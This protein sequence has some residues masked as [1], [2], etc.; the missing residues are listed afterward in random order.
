MRANLLQL[1]TRNWPIKGAALFLALMLYV[2]VQLQQPVT[3]SFDVDL[4]V[5]LPPGRALVHRPPKVRVQISGKGSQIL[6]LRSLA[7]DI[8]RRLPDTLTAT[9]WPIHLDPSEVELALPKGADVRVLDIRP[10]DITIALDSVARKDVRIVSLVTVMPESG[11]M[12]H[13]GLSISPTTARLVGPEKSLAGIESV[14]TVQTEITNVSGAFT[15]NVPI[16]TMPLGIVRLAPKQVTVTGEMGLIAERSFAGIP[17][18]TGAGAITSFIVTP[19]RVAVNVRGPEERVQA[20]TR[21]SLRVV[22]HITGSSG[23]IARITVVA[24]RGITARAIPDSVTLRRR[25]TPRRG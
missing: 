18:E 14:T 24:P 6:K 16:D 4:N 5:Q 12:L 7:G 13:G 1:I 2:A 19:A 8:T 11:Q 10:S 17:V 21:D 22:A 3:T 9:T 15:R 23:G 25:G 20:L